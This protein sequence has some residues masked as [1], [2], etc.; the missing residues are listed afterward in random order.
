MGVLFPSPPSSLRQSSQ[1]KASMVTTGK[2]W[3]MDKLP[4]SD[5]PVDTRQSSLSFL[6]GEAADTTQSAS[7][8][9]KR[10]RGR[11]RCCRKKKPTPWENALHQMR[12]YTSFQEHAATAWMDNLMA[13]KDC[14]L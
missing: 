10:K 2:L 1:I 5:A 12:A 8:T 9:G 6:P 13:E 11:K 4:W 3:S 7:A 14:R